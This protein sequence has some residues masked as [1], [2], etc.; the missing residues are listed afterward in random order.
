MDASGRARP[1]IYQHVFIHPER[2]HTFARAQVT[3][4]TPGGMSAVPT[5]MEPFPGE[6]TQFEQPALPVRVE[7]SGREVVAVVLRDLER[8][9]LD[10]VVQV[11]G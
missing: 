10:A 6:L 9:V 2:I 11:L 4:L 3:G 7:E 1:H 8:L 5:R